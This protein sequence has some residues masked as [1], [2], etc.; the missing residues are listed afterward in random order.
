MKAK[1]STSLVT[2]ELEAPT[3]RELFKLIAETQEVFGEKE[4]GCCHKTNIRFA[5]RSISGNDFFEMQCLDCNSFLSIGQ[6]KQKPGQLFPV[7][8]LTEQGKPSFKNGKYDAKNK[9]WTKY[10]GEPEKD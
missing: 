1:F 6:S 8:K 4:C 7:R 3:P 5:V 9:G 10:R 2:F